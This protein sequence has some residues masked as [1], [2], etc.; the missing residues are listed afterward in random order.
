MVNDS[1]NLVAMV[2]IGGM[3]SVSGALIGAIFVIGIPAIAPNNAL[4]GLLTSSI[5]L[6][7]VLLYFPRGLNQITYG[8]RD[9]ILAWAERRMGKRPAPESAPAPTAAPPWPCAGHAGASRS[10]RWRRHHRTM[11]PSRCSRSRS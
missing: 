2:V 4:V 6:L 9:A 8:V 1:L 11:R 3:G 5:G 10:R 7:V